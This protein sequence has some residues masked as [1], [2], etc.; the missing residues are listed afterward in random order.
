[1]LLAQDIFSPNCLQDPYPLYDRLRAEAPVQ[2][3]GISPFYLVTSFDAV[4]QA[5]ARVQ[6]FSSNLTATMWHQPDSPDGAVTTFPMDGPGGPTHVLATADDPAHAAHRKLVLPR[7][8]AKRIRALEPFIAAT[9][10]SLLTEAS[11]DLDWMAT[12]ADRLPMLVVAHLMGL[13]TADV[14]RLVGWAYGA[15]QLLDGLVDAD[16][17]TAAGVAATELGGYLVEQFDRAQTDP[18]DNLLGDFASYCAAERVPADKALFMLIQ[19]VSAGAEST[20]SLIGSA[21]RELAHRPTLAQRLRDVPGLIPAFL[22]EVLRLESPFRGHYRHVSVDTELGGVAL[23]ADSHLLLLWG[24]A[25]RDPAAFDDPHEFRLDRVNA[26]SHLAFG[27][28]AHFCVGAALA[29]LEARVVI[30]QLLALSSDIQPAG[31]A[32]W[33]PSLLVRRLRQLPLSV[34]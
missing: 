9:T 3:V 29:R 34:R 7:L 23:Q 32:E 33:L 1:M 17:L 21:A 28:G 14:D 8:A 10:E 24:A 31:R 27:K 15:T 12:V 30:S 16:Q 26:K 6:H 19:L 4:T 25:N 13:P 5:T 20:A 18:C 11:G 22:E 2:Q